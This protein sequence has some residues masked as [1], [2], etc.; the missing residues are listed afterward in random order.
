MPC[1]TRD[2]TPDSTVIITFQREIHMSEGTCKKSGGVWFL[3]VAVQMM[4]V[5]HTL[6]ELCVCT[7]LITLSTEKGQTLCSKRK[8]ATRQ[9][10]L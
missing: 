8:G 2:P 6:Y 10:L 5:H 1:H 3:V 7:M 4:N 9:A